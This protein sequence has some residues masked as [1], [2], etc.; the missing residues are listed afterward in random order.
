MLIAVLAVFCLGDAVHAM[1]MSGSE[2]WDHGGRLC[3]EDGCQ[4]TTSVSPLSVPAVTT[5]TTEFVAVPPLAA[6]LGSDRPLVAR[7]DQVA[8]RA[9]RSP[10]VV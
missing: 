9:P 8:P 7:K 5:A 2:Q 10:P 4:T 6:P 3:G 1:A